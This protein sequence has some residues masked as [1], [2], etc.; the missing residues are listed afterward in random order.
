MTQAPCWLWSLQEGNPQVIPDRMFS[1]SHVTSNC[2]KLW[3]TFCLATQCCY[4]MWSQYWMAHIAW[5][6]SLDQS[7]FWLKAQS[8]KTDKVIDTCTC[9]SILLRGKWQI[10][11]FYTTQQIWQ[12]ILVVP[13]L[14][15]LQVAMKWPPVSLFYDQNQD[16]KCF[17]FYVFFSQFCGFL[18]VWSLSISTPFSRNHS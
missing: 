5:C 16:D 1:S 13:S 8:C 15:S 3:R 7:E 14:L 11:L 9:T 12:C 17:L 2:I 6:H 10:S 18:H 4:L